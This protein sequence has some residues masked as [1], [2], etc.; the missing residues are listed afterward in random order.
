MCVC[1]CACVR[2][3][4][5]VCERARVNECVCVCV[6]VQLSSRC[7]C[8]CRSVQRLVGLRVTEC[9]RQSLCGR[10]LLSRP[11]NRPTE[12]A[13][14]E[15]LNKLLYRILAVEIKPRTWH[16]GFYTNFCTTAKT[17]RPLSSPS[18][19]LTVQRPATQ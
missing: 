7:Q 14:E 13:V 5:C 12:A 4:V 1:V 16:Q 8:R 3:C 10:D 11:G 15:R 19:Q 9:E 2:A 6:C 18:V 17:R